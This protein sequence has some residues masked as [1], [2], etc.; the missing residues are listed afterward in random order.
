ML[1]GLT[2]QIE[3]TNGCPNQCEYC[4][5]EKRLTVF[6]IPEI[7]KNYVHILD[8]NILYRPDALEVIMKLK[9]KGVKYELTSGIDFRRMTQEIANALKDSGFV[10]PRIAWDFGLNQQYKIKDAI[11]RLK[12]AGYKAK[13][14]SVFILYN[15]KIP[16]ED[17]LIKLDLLKIWNIKVNDCCF[18]NQTSPNFKPIH[19]TLEQLKDFR[20]RCRK[21]NQMVLFGIDPELKKRV[22]E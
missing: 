9:K 6:P 4:E 3:L 12:K 15:W 18:D 17:C 20:K 16:F 21:H 2:Q 11:N 1:S 19:W 8:M 10:K 13:E 5:E 7:T 14:I 22:S